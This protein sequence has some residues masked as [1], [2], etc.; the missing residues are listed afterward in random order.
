MKRILPLILLCGAWS[1]A[2]AGQGMRVVCTMV[3]AS[4]PVALVAAADEAFSRIDYAEAVALYAGALQERPNDPDVLWR[5]ARMY[6][7]LGEVEEDPG[8]DALLAKAEEYA[9]R[10]IRA[11]ERKAEGHT[12]LS[13]ALGYTA[14]YAGPKDQVRLARELEAE[15]ERAIALNPGDD[16]A[17]SIK[18]SFCRALGNVGWLERQVASLLWGSIPAGGFEEAEK[19][20][21]RAIVLAPRVMRHR[22]EL[23][24]LYRDMG[25]RD[26]ARR[27][28]ESAATLPIRT[29]IDRPRL[30]KIKEFLSTPDR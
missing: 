26:D 10:C 6:V 19:A 30:A 5:L 13:A 24:V 16:A 4:D 3:P 12:W 27:M 23:G 14:F 11:D 18:G 20:L 1:A 21:H 2:G 9:R 17:Y 29:A 15:L 25:R 7:C 22:Y 28:F 8:R